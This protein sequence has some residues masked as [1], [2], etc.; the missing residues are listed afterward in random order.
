MF[1]VDDL[2]KPVSATQP[3]GEDIAFSAEVDA[4]VRARQ[5]DDPSI[6]QGAW[7]ATL[8]EADWDFVAA[9]CAALIETRSKDLRLAVWLADAAARTR[10][11]RALGDA[12]LVLAGLVRQWWDQLHPLPD[13]G[14]FEQRIGNLCWI[15]ARLPPLI[16]ER[17]A[18]PED[19][20]HCLAALQE[21]EREIDERLGADGPSFT[22]AKALLEQGLPE[23]VIEAAPALTTPAAPGGPGP[24]QTRAQALAQLRSVADFFRRTEPHS[25]VAYLADKAAHWGE[26]PLHVWLQSV[27]KDPASYA[28][29][30][31]LLGIA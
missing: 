1:K 12:L 31:E 26:Q 22:A 21:L 24:L 18:A 11:L 15:A 7:V 8:K 16:R 4:I 6:E 27:V 30:Q 10:G 14:S 2:L 29:L 28:Q 9:R 25:P 20:A 23:A 3:G 17:E 5:A 13:D 19:M